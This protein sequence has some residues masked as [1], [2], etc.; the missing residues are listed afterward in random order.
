MNLSSYENIFLGFPIWWY[1]A[2]TIINTFLEEYDFTDKKVITFATSGGSEMGKTNEKL[3]DSCKGATLLE[4]KVFR[5]TVSKEELRS[6]AEQFVNLT[7]K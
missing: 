4:G 2:P 3:A 7:D 6:F 5:G 1:Q